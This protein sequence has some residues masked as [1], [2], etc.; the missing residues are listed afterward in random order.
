MNKARLEAF[1]DGVFAI[2][3]TLLILNIRLPETDY[4]HLLQALTSLLPTVTAYA[5]SFFV[6]GLYWVAH[7]ALFRNLAKADGTILWLNIVALL[8]ISFLPF[9]ASL[10]GKYPFQTIPIVIYGLNLI[11]TNLMGF[12]MVVYLHYHP[13][14]AAPHFN[15]KK[16][17]SRYAFVNGFYFFAVVVSFV[18][19]MFSYFIFIGVLASLVIYYAKTS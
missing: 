18:F 1:S 19:P 11:A 7:H 8:F 15:I 16:Q 10:L 5:M 6:I 17:V 9:P 13:E 3:I 12:I 2:V 4:A 14:L